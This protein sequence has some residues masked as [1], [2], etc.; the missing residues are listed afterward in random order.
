MLFLSLVMKMSSNL[1]LT[2][3]RLHN[4]SQENRVMSY[5]TFLIVDKMLHDCLSGLGKY[6]GNYEI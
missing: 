4:K 1:A 3:M 5:Q 6:E 2:L